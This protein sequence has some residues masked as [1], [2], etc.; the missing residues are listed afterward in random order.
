MTEELKQLGLIPGKS[1][2]KQQIIVGK[3][4]MI[5]YVGVILGQI[6]QII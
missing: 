4:M 2:V 3:Y 1:K 6:T 5:F